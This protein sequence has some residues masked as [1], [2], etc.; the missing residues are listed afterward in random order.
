MKK[1]TIPH[2]FYGPGLHPPHPY[3]IKV[4]FLV[5]IKHTCLA[6]PMILRIRHPIAPGGCT[7]RLGPASKIHAPLYF[8]PLQKI[9][10]PPA[11]IAW[12]S[13][14]RSYMHAIFFSYSAC[15]NELPA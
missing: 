4:E 1:C 12:C 13:M 10:Y 8:D 9:L 7:P 14:A 11:N 2:A 15:T 6:L 3:S 5:F